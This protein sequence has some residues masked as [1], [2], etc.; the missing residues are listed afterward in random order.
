MKTITMLLCL[1]ATGA[2]A[3]E[4]VVPLTLD[5]SNSTLQITL[6]LNIQ[7]LTASDTQT[8]P[9][10]GSVELGMECL[11]PL[12]QVALR[13]FHFQAEADFLFNLGI[14]NLAAVQATLTNAQLFYATPGQ[15]AARAPVISGTVQFRNVPV[16]L[17]G[18][19]NYNASG[20]ACAALQANGQPCIG[21][22]NLA[23]APASTAPVVVAQINVT[24][25]QV[26]CTATIPFSEPIAGLGR[27]YG[28]ANVRATGPIRPC[29]EIRPVDGRYQLNWSSVFPNCI[30]ESTCALGGSNTAWRFVTDFPFE[31]GGTNTVH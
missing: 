4:I 2:A 10:S 29:L 15:P 30:L 8:Q 12:S 23:D 14:P 27:L 19:L 16:V 25:N 3:A 1:A 13:H 7:G 9:L 28:Q 18:G 31:N 20:L 5:R 22:T 11:A 6:E 21:A 26:V 24:G 17:R